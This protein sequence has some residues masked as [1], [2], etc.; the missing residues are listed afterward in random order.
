MTELPFRSPG[1]VIARLRRKSGMSDTELAKEAGMRVGTLRD[2]ESGTPPTDS[3]LKDLANE[4]ETSPDAI[5]LIAGDFP[6]KLQ[7]SLIEHPDTAL[8]ALKDALDTDTGESNTGGPRDTEKEVIY[9]EDGGLLYQGDCRE[10]MPKLEDEGFDLIFADPPFN[11]DKDYGEDYDDDVPED[12]YLEWC[13]EWLDQATA[14]LKPGGALFV[15]NLPNWNIHFAS[16]LSQKLKFRNWIAVDIAFGLP[17]PNRLY[18]SHYSL[19]YFIK[20]SDPETFD[21]PRMPIDTCRH[22]G[23]E[24]SD[25]GGYKSEL[26]PRGMN[27]TDVWDDIPPVRHSKYMDR[28]ANQLSIKLVHRVIDMVTEEGDRVLDPFGGAGTTY[29]ACEIM[30]REWVGIELHDCSPILDRLDD[31]E[32]DRKQIDSIERDQNV[33]F[34]GDA[35]NLRMQYKD[36]FGFNMEDY[37][38]SESP[39]PSSFQ[40][41]LDSLD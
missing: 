15:Y 8:T 12:A 22:C 25:Y 32:T 10:V 14:L 34:T 2:I 40:Q 20:G 33:L 30:D 28:D 37:D 1:D 17:I 6:E 36:E 19:L 4:V 9:D 5:R 3:Q 38:L 11:L 18:P 39:M 31:L 26:N 29:A 13:Y 7:D 41:R 21:P 35:L 23:G 24:K 16:H 27:L